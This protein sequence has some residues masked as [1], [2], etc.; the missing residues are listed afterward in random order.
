MCSRSICSTRSEDVW[1]SQEASVSRVPLLSGHRP[2]AHELLRRNALLAHRVAAQDR[3]WA[4][5]PGEAEGVDHKGEIPLDV[6]LDDQRP[7]APV[8]LVPVPVRK[9]VVSLPDMAV[10]VVGVDHGLTS[11][12][13]S[14]APM[15]RN[16]TKRSTAPRQRQFRCRAKVRPFI[17][18]KV[19]G[20][21]SDG[22]GDRVAW[23]ASSFPSTSLSDTPRW[24]RGYRESR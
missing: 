16:V 14:T 10:A 18:P 17:L 24:D 21:E 2:A 3:P 23:T 11:R 9:G 8:P 5:D 7:A 15:R 6:G 1:S 4:G 22:D 13:I 12:A 20:F 19:E